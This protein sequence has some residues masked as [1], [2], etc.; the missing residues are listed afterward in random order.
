MSAPFSRT[1]NRNA[2]LLPTLISAL[3]F[4][5]IVRAEDITG[6]DGLWATDARNCDKIF[7]KTGQGFSF[8]KDSD[9]YGS[10]FIIDGRRVISQAA[11]CEIKT[12]KQDGEITH[13]IAG[14]ATDVMLSNM[15][16]SFKTISK[17]KILRIFPS[18]SE[19]EIPFERCVMQ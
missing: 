15:Q 18:V 6:I 7:V 4:S 11:R 17:D 12:K 3:V 2:W 19:M 5:S 10:G 16:A 1:T 9:L 13:L 8:A 14:C